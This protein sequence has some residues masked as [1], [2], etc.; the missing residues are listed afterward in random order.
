MFRPNLIRSCQFNFAECGRVGSFEFGWCL[1]LSGGP[2]FYGLL[3]KGAPQGSFGQL[4]SFL[5]SLAWFSPALDGLVGALSRRSKA[6]SVGGIR[7]FLKRSQNPF[8][9]S[10]RNEARIAQ[11]DTWT[12]R[13]LCSPCSPCSANIKEIKISACLWCVLR[14][15]AVWLVPTGSDESRGRYF[16]SCW[17]DWPRRRAESTSCSGEKGEFPKGCRHKRPHTLHRTALLWSYRAGVWGR[18]LST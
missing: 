3:T 9:N 16:E 13:G 2:C 12:F 18:S 14:F 17:R 7:A 11:L 4:S 10:I 8:G 15:C 5:F 1:P 6:A